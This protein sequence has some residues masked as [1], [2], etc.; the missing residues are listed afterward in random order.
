MSKETPAAVD[1]AAIDAA[2]A[3]GHAAGVKAGA[4]AE[5]TRISAIL[6]SDAAKN[7]P[8]AAR[9]MVD[10]G[11]ES[12]KAIEKMST[13]PEEKSEAAPTKTG[14]DQFQSKVEAGAPGI[15]GGEQGSEPTRVERLRAL[16]GIKK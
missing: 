14:A 1:Q 16:R 3:E 15:Q 8:A 12:A 6:D 4:E 2:R 10:L 5:R 7:R 11:I 13:L 9:M